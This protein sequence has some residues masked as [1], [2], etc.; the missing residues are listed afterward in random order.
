MAFG[1]APALAP[2]PGNVRNVGVSPARPAMQGTDGRFNDLIT[3]PLNRT[4]VPVPQ[5]PSWRE[6]CAAP[7]LLL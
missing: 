3:H 4:K 1:G 6:D 5:L 7:F 2:F